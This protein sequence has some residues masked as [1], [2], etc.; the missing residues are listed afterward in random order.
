V[1]APRDWV[2]AGPLPVTLSRG[3]LAIPEG[4]PLMA[5]GVRIDQL[6]AELMSLWG[7]I[8]AR[9]EK[10]HLVLYPFAAALPGAERQLRALVAAAG[11][12]P[13]RLILLPPGVSKAGARAVLALADLYLGQVPAVAPSELH[14]PLAAGLPLLLYRGTQMRSR[15]AA[16][17]AGAFDLPAVVAE[18][19]G[20]YE[21]RA[22]ALI[23][24]P[25]ELAALRAKAPAGRERLRQAKPE[26]GSGLLESWRRHRPENDSLR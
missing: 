2:P 25:G 26:S 12:D 15:R 18:T 17:V 23:S 20:E 24:A 6:T 1:I 10:A 3:E 5:S 22:L 19:P 8:L 14:D 7:R 11:A 13:R 4:V 21:E 16:A 9:T